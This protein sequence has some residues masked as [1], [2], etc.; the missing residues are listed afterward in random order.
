MP[1]THRYGTKLSELISFF[2]AISIKSNKTTIKSYEINPMTQ[3][4]LL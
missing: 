3:E 4:N 2:N 1:I